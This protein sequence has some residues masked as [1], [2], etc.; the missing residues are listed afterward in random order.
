MGL[1]EVRMAGK[2]GTAQAHNYVG[3]SRGSHGA[4]GTWRSRDHAWFIGFA[5]QEE[6]RYAL[7][8]LVEHGGFGADAAAPKAAQ[9]M[10]AALLK[11]PDIRE[12]FPQ[13]VPGAA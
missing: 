2:T 9:I 7:S 3:G 13:P 8:V 10:K 11:D 12:R 4:H 6:P 1:G 5:P